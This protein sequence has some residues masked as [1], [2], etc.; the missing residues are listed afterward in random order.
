M[1]NVYID[2]A[3]GLKKVKCQ[4]TSEDLTHLDL[5]VVPVSCPEAEEDDEL[6]PC[7]RDVSL[8]DDRLDQAV[9]SLHHPVI[10]NYSLEVWGPH[11]KLRML[12]G[13]FCLFAFLM[14]DLSFNER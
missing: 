11:G 10:F 9:G 3:Q 1:Y 7:W 2:K 13:I 14:G 12:W 4:S 5:S 6:L 8:R